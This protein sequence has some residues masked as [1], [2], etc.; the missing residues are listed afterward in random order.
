MID[1][2]RDNPLRHALRTATA[3]HHQRLE[4][5]LVLLSPGL[6]RA[7]YRRVLV[8]YHGFYAPLEARLAPQASLIPELQWPRRLKTPWLE[9]DLAALAVADQPPRCHALPTTESAAQ[10]IGCLYV[11]EGATLGGRFLCRRLS[12]GIGLTPTHGLCFLH[13]YGP[14]GG[15]MWRAFLAC[16]GTFRQPPQR[17]AVTAAA[18]ATFEAFEAWLERRGC[19]L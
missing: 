14:A 17:Q 2:A 15:A 7:A 3:E 6:D 18:V 5:R 11:L 8:A 19:L 13:G 12:A 16:L 4:R 10:A 1:A 9:R